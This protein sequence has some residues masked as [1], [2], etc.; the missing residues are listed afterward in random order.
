MSTLPAVTPLPSRPIEQRHAPSAGHYDTY[1]TCLRWDFGFTCAYCLLHEADFV[2]HGIK[3]WGLMSIE[4]VA[5]QSVSPDDADRYENCRYAC[6]F[7]NG[8]RASR[9]LVDRK[10]RKL[11][12]PC[13][14]AWGDN[15]VREADRI[16][17]RDPDASYTHEAY[18]LDDVR[19]QRM[20]ADRRERIEAALEL[21][22][23]APGLVDGL[24][25]NATGADAKVRAETAELLREQMMSA[26]RWL[27]RYRAIPVDHDPSCRCAMDPLT[28]PAFLVE[29]TAIER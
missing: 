5:L 11:L 27:D 3:G 2:E 20:R 18:D 15:F 6:R 10:G 28:L 1:R 13:R 19:K 24:L 8:A 22:A 14:A 29:P 23:R 16:T 7:C 9:P 4:H 21:L 26:R 12:D 17:P 25:A